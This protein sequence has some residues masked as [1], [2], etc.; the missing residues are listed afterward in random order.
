[1]SRLHEHNYSSWA[2]LPSE[3]NLLYCPA[4]NP[5]SAHKEDEAFI[6]EVYCAVQTGPPT[7]SQY[8]LKE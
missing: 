6:L 5:H 2:F 7:R 4:L 8:F 1:M 3:S